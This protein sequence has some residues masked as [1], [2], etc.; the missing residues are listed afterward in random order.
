MTDFGICG[1][2]A[3]RA[4]STLVRSTCVLRHGGSIACHR[5]S[6]L[7]YGEYDIPVVLPHRHILPHCLREHL[8]SVSLL[9]FRVRKFACRPPH[10]MVPLS[11]S[12]IRQLMYRS[13]KHCRNTRAWD[14]GTV[15]QQICLGKFQMLTARATVAAIFCTAMPTAR[16]LSTC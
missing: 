13:L 11:L 3:G 14:N 6:G 7:Q 15:H 1:I 5:H 12:E 8:R 4:E 10:Q 9:A 2:G 16:H